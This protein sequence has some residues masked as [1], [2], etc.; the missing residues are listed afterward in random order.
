M[1][2]WSPSSNQPARVRLAKH[3]CLLGVCLCASGCGPAPKA[4]EGTVTLDGAPLNE[5]VVMFVP[6]EHGRA[7]TG[8]KIEN[9]KYTLADK[10]GLLPGAYRVEILDNG[11]LH[12]TPNAKKRRTLPVEYSNNS[13]FRIDVP[14]GGASAAPLV[15]SYELKTKPGSRSL[16][17]QQ[18]PLFDNNHD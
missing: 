2:K 14:A 10:D 12:P 1:G 18:T 17:P 6:L 8:A 11:P 4:V 5:A 13:S 16:N 9:G 15:A 3:V 7:K